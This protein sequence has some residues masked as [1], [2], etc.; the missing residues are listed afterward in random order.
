M[1]FHLL[2]PPRYQLYIK[3][4]LYIVKCRMY[5]YI[6][7][8]LKMYKFAGDSRLDQHEDFGSIAMRPTMKYEHQVGF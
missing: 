6:E 3:T 7:K 5:K 1:D 4:E 8:Y 2:R